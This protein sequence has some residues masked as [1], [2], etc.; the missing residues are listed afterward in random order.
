MP[1]CVKDMNI[2]QNDETK[3]VYFD[4]LSVC[5]AIEDGNDD[6]LLKLQEALDY[7]WSIN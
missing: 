7:M 2:L 3:K 1:S 5:S 6:D 4:E